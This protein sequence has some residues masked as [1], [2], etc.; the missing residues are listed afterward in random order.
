MYFEYLSLFV[1]VVCAA[2]PVAVLIP[3]TI[4]TTILCGGIYHLNITTDPVELWA[5]PTSRSRIEKDYFDKTFGPFY[6]I[7][8]IIITAKSQTKINHTT[9]EGVEEFGPVFNQDFMFEVLEL[10]NKIENEIRGKNNV[11]LADVCFKPLYPDNQHCSVFSYLGWWQQ[12]KSLIKEVKED[13]ETGVLDNYLDHFKFCSRNPVSTKDS[14]LLH[15]SCLGK[16]GGPID[17]SVVLGG[18]LKDG[19]MVEDPPYKDANTVIIT[20]V[21]NNYYE[22]DKLQ[23]AMEWE[24]ALL[25]FLKDYVKSNKSELMDVA[26]RAERSIEDELKR[27]SEGEIVTVVISYLIMFLYIAV[28]LGQINQ[29]SRMLVNCLIIFPLTKWL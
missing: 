5:S 27:E 21:V 17:P 14:T 1:F 15:H 6:R 24:L 12:D 13:P 22:K 19:K 29:F 2:H 28:N 7:E 23:P 18:F 16:Y 4:I 8:H 10:Q 25:D 20:Y 26:Y 9:A 3:I 11:T